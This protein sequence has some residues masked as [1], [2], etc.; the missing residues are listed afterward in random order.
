VPHDAMQ[1]LVCSPKKPSMGLCS[2]IACSANC[3]EAST[4]V[5]DDANDG[6]PA[7]SGSWFIMVDQ[8]HGW[9]CVAPSWATV[10]GIPAISTMHGG[11]P[12]LNQRYSVLPGRDVAHL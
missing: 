2:N 11:P 8:I 9:L 4:P 3:K 10:I 7:T 1:G 5:Y 12:Q 6:R